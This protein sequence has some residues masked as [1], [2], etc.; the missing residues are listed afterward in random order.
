MLKANN[1][2]KRT[3]RLMDAFVRWHNLSSDDEAWRQ[4]RCLYA[5]LAPRTSE[6]LYIG[7]AWG[8]SVRGRWNRAA[9]SEFWDDLE[10]ARGFRMHRTI[11]GEVIL[12]PGKRLT[13]ELL[14][15]IESLLIYKIQPWGNI[16]S[17]RSRISRPT[18]SVACRGSWPSSIR[19]LRDE[20]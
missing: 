10:K 14:C 2:D 17:R 20:W 12:S 11:V 18:L 15:D 3:S 6:V 4:R 7:K 8:V 1:L 16:Q 9:K 19:V 5:Y 13:H